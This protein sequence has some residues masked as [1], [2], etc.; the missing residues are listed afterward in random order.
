MVDRY[1]LSAIPPA[2]TSR[3]AW[4]RPTGHRSIQRPASLVPTGYAISGVFD[5]SPL[6]GISVNQDLRLDAAEARRLSPL[7]WPN[8]RGR[9]FDA[10]CGGLE[11]SEFKRQSRALAQTWQEAGAQTRYEEIAGTNHFTVIDALADPQSMMTE[12][13]AELALAIK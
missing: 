2:A 12:R 6:V 11:S 10:V 3:P 7:S 5:L 1:S 13:A 9:I 8:V 4:S